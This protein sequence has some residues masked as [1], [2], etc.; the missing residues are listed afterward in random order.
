MKIGQ[1]DKELARDIRPPPGIALFASLFLSFS[2]H[3]LKEGGEKR[4]SD[5]G[6]Q[7]KEGK[8]GWGEEEKKKGRKVRRGKKEK[9]KA[10]TRNKMPK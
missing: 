2:S 5:L 10:V 9:L 1:P 8:R 3:L 6:K 7:D 4:G